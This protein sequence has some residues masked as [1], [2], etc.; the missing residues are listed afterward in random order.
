MTPK[1]VPLGLNSFIHFRSS[2]SLSL[3][4]RHIR[5]NSYKTS[6]FGFR[7]TYATAYWLRIDIKLRI[8]LYM[9]ICF[10]SFPAHLSGQHPCLFKNM[11]WKAG[12]Q[13]Q[14]PSL[15]TTLVITLLWFYLLNSCGLYLLFGLSCQWV[16]T[17]FQLEHS[18]TFLGGLPT[19]SSFLP[20][21]SPLLPHTVGAN[22]I[23]PFVI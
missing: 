5:I 1:L 16:L 13:L 19:I 12:S 14:Y 15:P 8:Q 2:T 21:S 18:D 6:S 7:P 10:S 17:S 4:H 22:L 3:L 9:T 23:T 11:S 20:P